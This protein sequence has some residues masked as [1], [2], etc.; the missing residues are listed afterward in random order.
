MKRTFCI[1]AAGLFLL[2]CGCQNTKPLQD[3]VDFPVGFSA[4]VHIVHRELEF[5]AV[6]T[7]AEDGT[8]TLHMQSPE[9]LRTLTFVQTKDSCTVQFLGLELKTPEILLPDTAFIK[10]LCAAMDG[11]QSGTRC[12]ASTQGEICTYSGMTD[13]GDT[14]QLTQNVR[15]GTLQALSMDG[16]NL[17]V[18]FSDFE[19]L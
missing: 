10:L 13:T 11:V 7:R 17:T 12:V 14:F 16:Q 3:Y 5:D 8:M 9:A 4:T 19:I 6:C 18:T 2:C 1:L 15:N